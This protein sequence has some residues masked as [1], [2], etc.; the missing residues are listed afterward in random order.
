MNIFR[1][2]LKIFSLNNT[3]YYA[4]IKTIAIFAQLIEVETSLCVFDL[5]FKGRKV[6]W[7]NATVLPA[8]FH[9]DFS[10]FDVST[11]VF[12]DWWVLKRPTN[13]YN[14]RLVVNISFWKKLTEIFH[15]TKDFHFSM[16]KILLKPY[17]L[18]TC[19]IIF[20]LPVVLVYYGTASRVDLESTATNVLTSLSMLFPILLNTFNIYKTEYSVSKMKREIFDYEDVKARRFLKRFIFLAKDSY[21]QSHNSVFSVDFEFLSNIIDFIVLVF[22]TLFIP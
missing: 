15:E 8:D 16:T 13:K 12:N 21:P 10:K 14:T 18:Q 4:M 11:L 2:T 7:D 5:L 1:V 22:T 3:L 6:A 17:S 20:S 19:L 9:N